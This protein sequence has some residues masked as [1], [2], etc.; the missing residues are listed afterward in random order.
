MA[1]KIAKKPTFSATAEVFTPND[2]CGHD[3]S[4]L[5]VKF[6]RTTREE[7]D[8][9][10]KIPQVDVLRQKLTGWDDFQDE[11]GNNLEFNPENL[12][13]LLNIPEALYGL[14]LAFWDSVVKAKGREKN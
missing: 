9:L 6:L 8:E 1:L 5:T 13:I 11:E 7:L 2:R 10:R 12:E 14:S 3:R 4:T